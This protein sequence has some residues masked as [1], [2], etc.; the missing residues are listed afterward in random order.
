M[1]IIDHDTVTQPLRPLSQEEKDQI[2]PLLQEAGLL[3]PVS[4]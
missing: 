1:G 2:P 3:D 4:G